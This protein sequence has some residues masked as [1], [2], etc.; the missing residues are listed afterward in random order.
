MPIN[1]VTDKKGKLVKK[2]GL[3]K[4]RVR[5]NYSDSFGKAKQIERTAYGL[6]E[7]KKLEK[8]LTYSVKQ[9]VPSAKITIKQLYEEYI[10][11]KQHEVREVTLSKKKEI[12]ENHIIPYFA[13]VK[14]DKL[15]VQIL[16]KW[17]QDI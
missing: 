17:K 5:V 11:T 12:V 7:A 9:Q 16:Q 3:Q 13:N 1:K 8:E 6:D 4:Y 14:L 10:K 15:N 2:D